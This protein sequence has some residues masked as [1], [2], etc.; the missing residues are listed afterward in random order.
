[1]SSSVTYAVVA[2]AVLGALVPWLGMRMLLPALRAGTPV[3][4]YRGRKVTPGLGVVWLVWSGT[5]IL[6]S[7]LA[8]IDPES[9]DPMLATLLTLAGML[10]LVAFALGLADDAFGTSTERGFRGHLAALA[11]GRL[12]TGGMKLF[13]ISLA[14]L[15]AATFLLA[16][17]NGAAFAPVGALV[18]ALPAG[19]AIALTSNLANLTDLR[20]GRAMKSYCLSAACG[21]V[22]SAMGMGYGAGES[23]L[24]AV[25]IRI[26]VLALFAFG[27]VLAVWKYD[28]G[29]MGMLGDAGANPMGA[30]AGLMIVA[31]LSMTG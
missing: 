29:E 17:R 18:V 2:A 31:G 25:A 11:K 19:A 16:G 30:V 15:F 5:A 22:S 27:P 8:H 21:V 7:L 26:T 10:A 14:S 28:L 1:M 3:T 4:N 20:P 12:T 6:A 24:G 9:F 23:G 13:G